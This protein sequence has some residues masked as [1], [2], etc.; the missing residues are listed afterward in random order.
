M[1]LNAAHSMPWTPVAQRTHRLQH[2]R[3]GKMTGEV[4]SL[5]NRELAIRHV[6]TVRC[7]VN[8]SR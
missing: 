4:D 1:A 5:L 2:H 8:D 7:L 6:A 3:L